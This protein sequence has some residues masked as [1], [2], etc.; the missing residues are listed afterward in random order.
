MIGSTLKR[1]FK[2]A[3]SSGMGLFVPDAGRSPLS[4]TLP[5]TA[6]VETIG[7][8]FSDFGPVVRQ[9]GQ[10]CLRIRG[11]Q[12]EPLQ[13]PVLGEHELQAV[14]D[15]RLAVSVRSEDRQTPLLP[16]IKG[17][18]LEVGPEPGE[19][20]RREVKGS[21]SGASG[22]SDVARSSASFKMASFARAGA[23]WAGEAFRMWAIRM[24]ASPASTCSWPLSLWPNASR[25]LSDASTD[26][27]SSANVFLR[28]QCR[29]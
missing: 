24:S 6:P 23:F 3:A 14:Y 12:P 29:F 18:W 13:R 11:A 1:S 2:V 4:A 27:E 20:Q 8:I 15:A 5:D 21:E 19:A 9:R 7:G 22:F 25:K 28:Y 26:L 17:L 10:A 16:E